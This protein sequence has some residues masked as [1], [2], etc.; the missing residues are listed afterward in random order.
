MRS[1]FNNQITTTTV[2]ELKKELLNYDDDEV[3]TITMK[4]HF[5]KP[6]KSTPVIKTPTPSVPLRG[7][8]KPRYP[9]TFRPTCEFT[10]RLTR[11]VI[12]KTKSKIQIN[13]KKYTKE[14]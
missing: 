7:K 11:Y 10:P 13:I 3:I 1:N 2:G 5:K 12:W 14:E 8:P 6:N 4:F 9:T